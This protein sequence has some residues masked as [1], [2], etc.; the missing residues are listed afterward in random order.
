M[1]GATTADSPSDASLMARLRK[2]DERALA[3]LY[4]R[5]GSMVHALARGIVGGDADAE[6]VTEDVFIQ[7][8]RRPGAYD[9]E[10]GA[11][12][13]YLATVTRHRALDRLRA[14]RRRGAAHERAAGTNPAGT[15]VELAAAEPTDALAESGEARAR[16]S[17][18][19][20][21]INPDQ[22][23][24]IELAYF[25][26]LSQSEIARRLGEPLGTIK[27]RIRDGMAKLRA[28]FGAPEEARP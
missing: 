11:M 23:R 22:R 15:A 21:D 24:A 4:D 19:L 28:A 2:G 13:A 14:R 18:A 10:R 3:A 26:G 27:T 8:W 25:D 20:S 6:E 1:P 17:R 16:L 5:H 9:P 12:E 7:L